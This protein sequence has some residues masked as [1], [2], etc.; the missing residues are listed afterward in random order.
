VKISAKT[1]LVVILTATLLVLGSI[2]ILVWRTELFNEV[3]Q[4]PLASQSSQEA[5]QKLQG[6]V[7]GFAKRVPRTIAKP[8]KGEKTSVP[9]EVPAAQSNDN[10][11]REFLAWISNL[12]KEDTSGKTGSSRIKNEASDYEEEKNIIKSVILEKW[13]TGYETYNVDLYMSSIWE[14]DFFYI[15]DVGT[16]DDPSDDIILRGGQKE[17]ESANRVFKIYTKKIELNL[18]PLSDVEFLS[19]TIATAKY[20]YG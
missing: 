6:S 19:D 1:K 20:S 5:S 16:P 17:R 12:N 11:I 9:E 3:K 15:S 10:E 8:P 18:S 13:R 4:K 14:D 7:S 2:G